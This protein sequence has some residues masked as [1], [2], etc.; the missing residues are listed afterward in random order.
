MVIVLKIFL[1]G[2]VILIVAIALNSLAVK[3]GISTWYP[4]LESIGENGLVKSFK[5]VSIISKLFLFLI[6]PF[7]LGAAGYLVLKYFK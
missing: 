3:F 1:A 4:F 2:W 5:E 7:L 6:Y